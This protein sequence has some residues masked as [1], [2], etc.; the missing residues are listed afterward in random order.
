MEKLTKNQL[1]I[2]D[3]F[4]KNPFLKASILKIM[5]TLNKKS[6]QRVH[7]T[8]KF[9]ADKKILKI[10]KY[11]NSSMA[12]ILL[13]SQ[14]IP[15]LSYLEEQE[16]LSKKIP[17]IEKILEFKEFLDDIVLVTGSY[18][19]GTQTKQ[20]DIDLAIITKENAFK[21]QKLAENLT[22]TF[23]PKIHAI[24]FTYKDFKEMLLSKEE[25][26]GKEV[27]KNCLIFRNARRYYEL[28]IEAIENGFKG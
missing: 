12:S 24:A 9:L 7:E 26:F 5:K 23:H 22:L 19:K 21:K 11:G 1:E 27:F 13:G 3:L 15:L 25:N 8:I 18:A 20:S 2:L 28:L 16:A 10:E 14:S 17:N 6:Y 4:R